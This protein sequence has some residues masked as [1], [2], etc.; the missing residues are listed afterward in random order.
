M[1]LIA[2]ETYVEYH[3]QTT[4][5]CIFR[6]DQGALNSSFNSHWIAIVQLLNIISQT[7][8]GISG[9]DLLASQTLYSWAVCLINR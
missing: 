9:I 5:E 8:L 7:V 2:R 3:N 4:L 6:Y 1:H